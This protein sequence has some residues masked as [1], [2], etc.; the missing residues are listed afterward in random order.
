MIKDVSAIVSDIFF[1]LLAVIVVFRPQWL[2]RLAKR[3]QEQLE[4]WR[5]HPG[6]W[7]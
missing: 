7:S 3:D 1:F 2:D 5:T 6:Q 4:K